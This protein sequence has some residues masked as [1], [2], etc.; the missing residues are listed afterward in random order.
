MLNWK[1]QDTHVDDYNKQ[2]KDDSEAT[3][4]EKEMD[5]QPRGVMV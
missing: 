1:D 2:E 4:Q 5:F 3:S